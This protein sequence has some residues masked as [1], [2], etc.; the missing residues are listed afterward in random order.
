MRQIGVEPY[1]ILRRNHNPP[2]LTLNL[3]EFRVDMDQQSRDGQSGPNTPILF[4]EAPPSK[5]FEVP[6]FE[7]FRVVATQNLDEDTEMGDSPNTVQEEEQMGH[8]TI[9]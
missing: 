1:H 3:G 2:E 7:K 8:F 5:N 9:G 6:P 4:L